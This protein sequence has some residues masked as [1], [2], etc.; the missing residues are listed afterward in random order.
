M[1]S[2][3]RITADYG[4][5][6]EALTALLAMR[7]LGDA[8]FGRKQHAISL[9]YRDF[10]DAAGQ[11]SVLIGVAPAMPDRPRDVELLR[12]WVKYPFHARMGLLAEL[13]KEY[14]D[15]QYAGT[16][17]PDGETPVF[18]LT[19]EGTSAPWSDFFETE[20]ETLRPVI[21][22]ITARPEKSGMEG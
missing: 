10:E 4:L 20:D 15:M 9:Y 6:P 5:L 3:M 21:A 22:R 8:E 18:E 12:P 7:R 1:L 2:Q 19:A 11:K 14:L 16:P 13:V 17:R